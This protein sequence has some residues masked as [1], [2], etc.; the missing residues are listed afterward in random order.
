MQ[1]QQTNN[2]SQTQMNYVT[3]YQ[4]IVARLKKLG[5]QWKLLMLTSGVLTWI[6]YLVAILGIELI[7]DSLLPLPRFLRMTMVISFVGCA[8]WFGYLYIFKRIRHDTSRNR[9]AAYI[10]KS[11]PGM[12][13]C[14]ISA[15][16]LWPELD[17]SKYG[18]SIAFIEKIIQQ[19]YQSLSDVQSKRVLSTELQNL[20][21][22]FFITLGGAVI[23][24]FAVLM[25]PASLVNFGQAFKAIPK[26]PIEMLAVSI[27]DVSPGDYKVRHGE[28]VQIN[29][30]VTGLMGET[31]QLYYR[32]EEGTW[33]T[34]EMAKGQEGKDVSDSIHSL[35]FVG[36]YHITL[37]NVTQSFEY[38]ISAK[39][40]K[41]PTYKITVI[42]EPVVNRFQLTLNFPRYTNLS[43]QVLE[44]N[45]GDVTA[46][47][48]TEVKFK[49]ESNKPLASAVLVFQGTKGDTVK[50]AVAESTKLHG[51]F[52][53]R[54]SDKYHILLTDTEGV[55]NSKPIQYVVRA[56]K[57]KEPQVEILKP[58]EDI[59]LDDSM[60]IPLEISA[61]DD[62]GVKTVQLVYRIEGQEEE[63][64]V[65]LKRLDKPL[66]NRRPPR[67][68]GILVGKASGFALDSH[69]SVGL[70]EAN[71]IVQYTWDVNELDLFPE[72]VVSYHAEAIDAD[73]VSGPNIGRSKTYTAR[74]PSMMELY[75]EMEEEQFAQVDGIED[76]L[77]RQGEAKDVVDD[78]IDQ[79]RKSQEL[80]WKE[81]KQIEQ[82][83]K[84]QEQIE[85]TAQ[86]LIKQMKQTAK[87]IEKNQ[88][89]DLETMQKYQEL[90]KLMEQALS[91]EQ[92]D[93]LRKLSE[94]LEKQ[95]LSEKEKNLL[96]A[97]FNQEA[98]KQRLEQMIELYKKL[99]LQQKLEAAANR[100][101]E[102][103][104]RQTKVMEKAEELAKATE[105][106]P[107][108][109]NKG[110][111]E[112][113]EQKVGEKAGEQT[114]SEQQQKSQDMARQEERIGEQLEDLHDDLD[115]ISQ[116][117]EQQR[118][119]ERIGQEVARLNREAQ[120][121][122]LTQKLRAAGEQFG[123][124][125]AQQAIQQ[126]MQALAGMKN[127]QQGLDN[128]VDFMRG[129]NAE[130]AMAAIQK[131][132]REG[133]YVSQ[134]HE[135][136]MEKTDKMS[137]K[138]ER[139]YIRSER[140]ALN[141]LASEELNLAEAT[142]ILASSLWDL[143]KEQMMIDPKI[144]WTLNSARDAMTRSARA[145]EDQKPHLAVPIQMQA[146][147]DVNQAITDLLKS[148]DQM[149][150]QMSMSGLD[151]ML[152]QLQQLVQ[153]QAKLNEMAQ[154]MSE[155]MR[156][157]GQTPG[158]EE[159]LKRMAYEQ[160]LI[161][162]ATE[163]LAEKM[164]KMA[165]MLGS[166]RDVAK[167]MKE[168]ERDLQKGKLDQE[169][170]DKQRKI[171]TRMLESAKSLQKRQLSKR[172]KAETAPDVTYSESPQSINPEL[173][174]TLQK[175]DAEMRSS[176]VENWPQEYRELVRLYYKA[177][178]EKVQTK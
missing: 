93:I 84:M 124:C 95:R 85:K 106:P 69:L 75:E 177:L 97:K 51:S 5:V 18:Y 66:E 7:I 20:K 155:Q 80:T 57:D 14:L 77:D 145:L 171:L 122:Q 26:T 74:F 94:A 134:S 141:S 56:I 165:Q 99:L 62:Y 112:V 25:F 49:G 30:K 90:R 81:E 3:S 35:D 43:P 16:Q 27:S 42:K 109:F 114:T 120:N 172:R 78:I 23:L 132:I 158:M 58:G 162:E 86:D 173:L 83:S 102:L 111:E 152:E 33:R 29:A 161:R 89:F 168:V 126:G 92:K 40:E 48:G 32:N 140:K 117:M 149:N 82:V 37:K 54:R 96:S 160:S 19:A 46:L 88:L 15:I 125:Q 137:N 147:S 22:S 135:K 73:N 144:V 38:H 60:L 79:L 76:L 55:S 104:E 63:H 4:T 64:A 167:D 157:Q 121:N 133:L 139:R 41:S 142:E 6:A 107:A 17:K 166:L 36:M 52:W 31:A 170:L 101:K 28:D 103:V 72:D 169:L 8:L 156:R 100:A 143:G 53:V 175:L 91:E 131:A 119:Y 151:S 129:Q 153:N 34:V 116:E 105:I 123:Q 178:S 61:I 98:F 10:E 13:N 138:N 115:S 130:E 108:P 68:D 148:L 59:V 24:A 154:G 128:A 9:V 71:I 150:M 67:S 39:G 11:Y 65:S 110:G 2:Q 113:D 70:R 176:D 163:R 87:D 159:M 47:I 164:D 21:K 127:L 12:E 1:E 45:S 44:P 118:G 146:L 50:L 136:L 174:K